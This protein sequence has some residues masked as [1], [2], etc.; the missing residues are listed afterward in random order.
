ML[1]SGMQSNV[2]STHRSIWQS[3]SWGDKLFPA[4]RQPAIFRREIVQ[5]DRAKGLE[6]SGKRKTLTLNLG[7]EQFGKLVLHQRLEY[8]IGGPQSLRVFIV[9]E[10]DVDVSLSNPLSIAILLMVI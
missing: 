1:R 2:I 6:F 10:S 7:P 3:V 4:E 9:G 8:A 5:A